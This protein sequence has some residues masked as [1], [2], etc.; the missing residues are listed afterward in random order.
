MM[1]EANSTENFETSYLIA[2]KSEPFVFLPFLIAVV[3]D[4]INL[5]TK[6]GNEVRWH[7]LFSK[8]DLHSPTRT[9]GHENWTKIET[10]D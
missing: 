5:T 4:E 3:G 7:F 10:N 2:A 1:R 8:D 6:I 9:K